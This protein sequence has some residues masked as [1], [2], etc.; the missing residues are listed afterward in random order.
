MTDAAIRTSPEAKQVCAAFVAA[1]SRIGPAKKDSVNPHFRSKFASLQAVWDACQP[2]L[3]E[4][5]LGMLQAVTEASNGINITTRIIH[6]SG[7]WIE[8]GPAFFPTSKQDAQG[9]GSATTYGKRYSLCAMLGVVADDDD[10]GNKAVDA[11]P[12]VD[13]TTAPRGSAREV[14]TDAYNALS[15]S[16]QESLRSKMLFI[17]DVFDDKGI[18]EAYNALKD[19]NLDTEGQLAMSAL[20]DS[21]LRNQL[22]AEGMRRRTAENR[23]VA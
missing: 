3:R 6:E 23:K 16:E 17:C 11:A 7:E 18:V 10:D 5:K 19:L 1:Q 12:R 14:T 9:F 21:T 22:K 13:P 20:M 2:A 15:Q 4:A 8:A